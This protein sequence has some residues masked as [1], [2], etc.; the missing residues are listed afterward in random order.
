MD[1]LSIATAR[2]RT[3]CWV[4]GPETAQPLLLVHGNLVTGRFFQAVANEL[5]ESLPDR[6]A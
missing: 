2:L 4:A 6:R 1:A 5:G 3:H